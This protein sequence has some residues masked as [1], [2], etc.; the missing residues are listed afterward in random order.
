[1]AYSSSK[2]ENKQLTVFRHEQRET[3]YLPVP[4]DFE[5]LPFFYHF[6]CVTGSRS[7]SVALHFDSMPWVFL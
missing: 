6:D 1:M 3:N 2:L 4:N 7:L 5:K